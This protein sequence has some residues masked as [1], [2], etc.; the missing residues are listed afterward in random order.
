MKATIIILCLMAANLTFNMIK[1]GQP[2]DGE[3]SFFWCCVATAIE[4][5]LLFYAGLFDKFS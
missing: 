2:R 4:L 5:V 3:Y 1:D